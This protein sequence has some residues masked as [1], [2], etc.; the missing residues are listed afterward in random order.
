MCMLVGPQEVI[1]EACTEMMENRLQLH[2]MVLSQ[3]RD[4]ASSASRSAASYIHGRWSAMPG[5]ATRAARAPHCP[6]GSNLKGAAAAAATARGTPHRSLALTMLL[7][8]SGCSVSACRHS[9]LLNAFTIQCCII[10][11][12][13]KS[14]GMGGLGTRARMYSLDKCCSATNGL[15]HSIRFAIGSCKQMTRDPRGSFSE[16]DSEQRA[17][18]KTGRKC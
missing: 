7:T 10:H 2:G 6:R 14:K 16:P 5:I 4:D 17:R 9:T 3:S 8:S 18:T 15:R 13:R 12:G 1:Q 11:P